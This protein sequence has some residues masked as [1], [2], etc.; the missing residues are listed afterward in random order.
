MLATIKFDSQL[1]EIK[2]TTE[3]QEKEFWIRKCHKM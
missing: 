3:K 1:F 2:L